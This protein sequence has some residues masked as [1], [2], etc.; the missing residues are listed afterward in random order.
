MVKLGANSQLSSLT[1]KDM[2]LRSHG[3]LGTPR[4]HGMALPL[5]SSTG[6][7]LGEQIQKDTM[8]LRKNIRVMDY[9]LLLKVY[10]KGVLQ[11]VASESKSEHFSFSIISD[12]ADSDVDLVLGIIDLPQEW[13]LKCELGRA[14]KTVECVLRGENPLDISTVPVD[15]YQERFCTFFKETL[16]KRSRRSQVRKDERPA[17]QAMNDNLSTDCIPIQERRDSL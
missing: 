10:R 16:F 4:N 12:V 7:I 3:L 6:V 8:F 11:S 5:L 15:Y 2:N 1:L 13:T 9:S 14:F 17:L